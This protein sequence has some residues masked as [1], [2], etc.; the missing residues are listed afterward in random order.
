MIQEPHHQHVVALTSQIVVLQLSTF[1]T[2]LVMVEKPRFP[3]RA[4]QPP[5]KTFLKY[6]PNGKRLIVA[7]CA[8]FARSFN[9]GDLGEPDIF[10]D[11]H[12]D[13]YAVAAGVHIHGL[14]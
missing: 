11:T 7:G 14:V 12:E 9:T 6:S 1:V 8:N 2:L 4:A 5:G 10:D 3:G 13:T